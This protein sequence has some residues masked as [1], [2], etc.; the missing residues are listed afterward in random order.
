MTNFSHQKTSI[1]DKQIL[2][3]FK[4]HEHVK[5][6]KQWGNYQQDALKTGQSFLI[7]RRKVE[8]D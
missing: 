3:S 2:R 7:L 5:L 6:D 1:R 8:R 4:A